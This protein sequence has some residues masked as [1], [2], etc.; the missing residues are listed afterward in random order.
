[1][2][3]AL[4]AFIVVG[5]F[6]SQRAAAQAIAPAGVVNRPIVADTTPNHTKS[7]AFLLRS[8]TGTLGLVGGAVVVVGLAA[9]TGPH[10]CDDCGGTSPEGRWPS[11]RLAAL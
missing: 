6:A 2:T 8:L 1:M 3:R 5:V 4:I 9:A 7:A 10:A 11:S